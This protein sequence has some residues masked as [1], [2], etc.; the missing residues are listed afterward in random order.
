MHT[1]GPWTYSVHHRSADTG[2]CS[3]WLN[4]G[5][6]PV[7]DIASATEG[8]VRAMAAA[9]ALLSACREALLRTP[10]AD[11]HMKYVLRSAISLATEK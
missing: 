7:A 9:P 2:L 1:K 10:E 8:D 6:D 5:D 11:A 3:A 4:A